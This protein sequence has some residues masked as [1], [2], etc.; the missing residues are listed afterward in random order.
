MKMMKMFKIVCLAVMMMFVTAPGIC[1]TLIVPVSSAIY[2]NPTNLLPN[3]NSSTELIFLT[4]ILGF[5]PG[6]FIGKEDSAV[7]GDYFYNQDIRSLSNWFSPNVDIT[8]WLYAVVKVDGPNDGWYGYQRDDTDGLGLTVP[9]IPGTTQ[10]RYGISHVSFFGST[11]VP[12]PA[13]LLLLG[14]G[15]VGLAGIRRGLKK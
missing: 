13:T 5:S 10:F 1:D 4:D 11:P 15:L 6:A 14:L 7:P 2:A 3:S 12:E 9:D 8:G